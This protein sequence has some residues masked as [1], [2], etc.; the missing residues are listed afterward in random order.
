[1]NFEKNNQ[2]D[3]R[4]SQLLSTADKN[5]AM[6]DMEFLDKLREQS[7]T[8]FL[9]S[10][11]D[12]TKKPQIKI[13]PIWRIIMKSKITKI[14]S[15]VMII[16]LVVIGVTLINK[17]A[18]PVYAFE[19]TIEAMRNITSVHF[20]INTINGDRIE[21]WLK[22]NPE[23]GDNEKFYI[24]GPEFKGAG[25][26]N[27]SYIFMKKTNTVIHVTGPSHIIQFGQF[28][29]EMVETAKN[30]NGTIQIK[31]EKI[32]GIKSVILLIIETDD[33][34]MESR[35]NPVTKLP[36]SIQ[37]M[38]KKDLGPGNILQ[39]ME[40]FSFNESLP[41]GIFDFEIPEGAQVIEQ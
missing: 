17:T 6:P 2:K 13:I 10:S 12:R 36:I 31:S 37:L 15:V 4:L 18:T 30:D 9:A 32:E 27:D 39:S 40:D 19:Q 3:I 1:M 8:E 26:L 33:Y 5:T 24:D 20:F 21:M 28:I 35:I 25:T 41:E 38:P 7:T 29:E 16:G 14:A 23:I 34:K 22:V 11:A